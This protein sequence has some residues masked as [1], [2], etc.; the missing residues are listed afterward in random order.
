MA[1][2]SVTVAVT[3]S[4]AVALTAGEGTVA[5][6]LDVTIANTSGAETLYWGGPDV[7][8]AN[9]V[10]ILKG[11]SAVVT[12]LLGDALWLVGSGAL[13]ARLGYRS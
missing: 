7:T 2:K 8:T 11:T 6:S 1:L 10:P 12:L 13:D 3:S 4:S 9:G 5:A